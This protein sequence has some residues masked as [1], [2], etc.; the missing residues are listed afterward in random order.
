MNIPAPLSTFRFLGAFLG[1]PHKPHG[2]QTFRLSWI[3]IETVREWFHIPSNNDN[4][5][6]VYGKFKIGR[7]ERTERMTFHHK[8]IKRWILSVSTL[9]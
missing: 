4:E 6:N 1:M 9:P 5:S 8:I 2:W 3:E 7:Q